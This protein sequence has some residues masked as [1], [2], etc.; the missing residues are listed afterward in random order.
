MQPCTE[1]SP[2]RYDEGEGRHS[3]DEPAKRKKEFSEFFRKQMGLRK[4]SPPLLGRWGEAKGGVLNIC[5]PA[6]SSKPSPR[7]RSH[8]M[9]EVEECFAEA[10]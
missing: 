3:E 7:A 1:L 8:D 5:L 6:A 2:C 9:G 4:V 10:Q